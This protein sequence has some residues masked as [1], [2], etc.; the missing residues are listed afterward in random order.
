MLKVLHKLTLNLLTSSILAV[1]PS[2]TQDWKK[3]GATET[4]N[5]SAVIPVD[6]LSELDA[7]TRKVPKRRT[8]SL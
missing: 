8:I 7:I 3:D 6:I 5:A 1:F 2:E 4:P